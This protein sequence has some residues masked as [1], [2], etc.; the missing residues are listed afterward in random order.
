MAQGTQRCGP[1]AALHGEERRPPSAAA[2]RTYVARTPVKA[3]AL[4]VTIAPLVGITYILYAY[5]PA[6]W[7]PT[8]LVGLAILLPSLALLTLARLQLGSS[9][10]VTAQATQ[11]VK[12]GLYARI[13]NPVYVFGLLLFAGLLLY[14]G[15]DSYLFALVPLGAMQWVRAG[16]EARVLEATFGEDYRAY[17]ARTWF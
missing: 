8:R 15:C 7:T 14:T 13:R 12:G 9:F 1:R 10:S 3:S 11:L 16:R 6:V 17:R 4:A 2:E 5:A